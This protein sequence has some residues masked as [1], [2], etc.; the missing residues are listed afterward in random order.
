MNTHS[1]DLPGRRAEARQGYALGVVRNVRGLLA[2]AVLGCSGAAAAPPAVAEARAPNVIVI[3]ADDLGYGD[4][5]AYGRSRIRTPNID[6]LAASG[7]RFTDGYVTAAVCAP[8]RAAMLTGRQQTRYGWEF[9]PA[10]RDQTTGVDATQPMIGQLLK[11]AGY[12]TAM[13]G[14]WHLGRRPGFHPLDRGFDEYF[15]VLDGATEYWD[16]KAP[17]DVGITTP[18]DALFSRE[19]LPIYRGRETVQVD[20]Y[21]TDVFTRE[22]TDYIGRNKAKPFFL[23]LAYTAPHT[24]LQA[25]SHYLSR[26]S[27]ES[28]EIDRIYDA[29]LLSLDDGVGRILDKLEAE[30]LR[31]D[32]IVVFLSDNGCPNYVRGACSNGRLSGYKAYLWEGGVRVPYIFSWPRAVRPSVSAQP[33]SSLDILPTVAAAAGASVP[34]GREGLDLSPC[35]RDPAAC[36][37]RALF[38]RAGP[39]H[40]VRAGDWKLIVV[41]KSDKPAHAPDDLNPPVAD[42]VKAE[43]S[44]L[45][46][47]VLLYNL[48]A[49]P[50]EKQ[51]VAAAHPEIVAR[52]QA[53]FAQWDRQNVEPA[54]TSRR[55]FRAAVNGLPVEL[56]N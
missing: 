20:G 41:N 43:V 50:G 24:P 53:R 49:D 22:A 9:N 13:V 15:G 18:V 8:S 51:T 19:Q 29:M 17:G 23:Y 54:Y 21:L 32:T 10:G 55:Q 52:L 36:P 47:W 1:N 16:T 37:Q 11:Q 46:Q 26:A 48:K 6:R 3:V 28:R 27:S 25:A 35:L 4:V 38:W 12:A 42:G 30:G 40:A 5:S 14:K 33:V 45:G 39:N 34:A 56:V 44:P 31:E 7:V 2:A